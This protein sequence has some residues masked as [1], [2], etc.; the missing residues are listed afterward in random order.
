MFE[1]LEYYTYTVDEKCDQN[2]QYIM[3]RSNLYKYSAID[4][5]YFEVTISP[6]HFTLSIVRT[7][8][9]SK[10]KLQKIRKKKWCV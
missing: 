8:L 4:L 10:L 6:T 2:N 3:D 7:V 9:E 1:I 5:T